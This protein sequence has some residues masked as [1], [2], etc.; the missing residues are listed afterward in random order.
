[1]KP[2]RLEIRILQIL[3]LAAGLILGIKYFDVLLA[4]LGRLCGIISPLVIGAV[5]AFILN[6]PMKKLEKHYFPHSSRSLVTRS[7]RPV[8]LLLSIIFILLIAAFVIRMIIPELINAFSLIIREAITYLQ[9]GQTW[10]TEHSDE[11]PSYV[12]QF[13]GK[14]I[15]LNDTI[16]K[17]VNFIFQGISGILGSAFTVFGSLAGSIMDGVFAVIFALYLLF[18]KETLI[19]QLRRLC[20]RYIGSGFTLRMEYITRVFNTKFQS[21]IIGQCLEAIILGVLCTLGM[22]LFRFPY[23]LMVGATIAAT[24][25]IP[26]LGAYLGAGIG[27]F[28]IFTENPLQALGFLVFI[29]VLQQLEG[30]LIYPRTVGSS[31]G[32][33]GIWVIAAVTVGGGFAGI[34]GMLVGVP[35]TA[36]IYQFICDD[37]HRSE[38]KSAPK[39]RQVSCQSDDGSPAISSDNANTEAKD[40]ESN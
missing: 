17:L 12:N 4:V 22:T 34:P 9:L 1:M 23:A 20:N 35:L 14:E 31:I 6:I 27:A 40:T 21:F 38:R 15:D 11:L 7:R 19:G 2:N 26:I 3:V 5:I 33:P 32:L 16:R 8:C 39:Q 25:L 37:I 18:G 24:A 13:I 30:N 36:S 29:I 10:L 28:M